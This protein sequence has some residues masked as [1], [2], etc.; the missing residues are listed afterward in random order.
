RSRAWRLYR[1]FGFTDVLRHFVFPGDERQ[2]AVLGR[3]LPLP[4]HPAR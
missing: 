4:Q 1:G 3:E 2:F